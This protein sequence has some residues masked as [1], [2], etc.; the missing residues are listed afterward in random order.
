MEGVLTL[1]KHII[2]PQGLKPYSAYISQLI[3]G[4]EERLQKETQI[5]T[6]ICYQ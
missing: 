4:T 2:K 3:Y 6:E 5:H 1:L